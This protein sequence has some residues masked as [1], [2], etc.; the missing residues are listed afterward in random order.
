MTTQCKPKVSS[1]KCLGCRK[2]IPMGWNTIKLND[3]GHL[4]IP[5][6]SH[7]YK[8]AKGMTIQ[9]IEEWLDR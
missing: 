5:C 6:V 3:K 7:A 4:C 9:S 1:N 2:R 8:V